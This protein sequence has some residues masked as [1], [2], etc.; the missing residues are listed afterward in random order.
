MK[1]RPYHRTKFRSNKHDSSSSKWWHKHTQG[2]VNAFASSTL[3]DPSSAFEMIISSPTLK[4]MKSHWPY[5]T[6]RDDIMNSRISNDDWNTVVQAERVGASQA[7]KS[8]FTGPT[9]LLARACFDKKW[10]NIYIIT[11]RSDFCWGEKR[12]VAYC[13]LVIVAQSI[14]VSE[15]KLVKNQQLLNRM[16]Q[17]RIVFHLGQSGTV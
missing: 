17:V 13:G 3:L 15:W 4:F 6:G 10:H 1:D 8:R 2:W 11:A 9:R 16:Q 14:H 12:A 5:Q 7:F